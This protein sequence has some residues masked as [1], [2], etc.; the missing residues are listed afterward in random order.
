[1][2]IFRRKVGEKQESSTELNMMRDSL[3][4]GRFGVEP[5]GSQIRTSQTFGYSYHVQGSKDANKE[6]GVVPI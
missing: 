1:M 4:M 6:F 3:D 5:A 2:R